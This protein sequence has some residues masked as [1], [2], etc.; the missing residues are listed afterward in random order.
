MHTGLRKSD[1]SL[2][3]TERFACLAGGTILSVVGMRRGGAL[4]MSLALGGGALAMLGLM[5]PTST[6]SHDLWSRGAP[7]MLGRMPHGGPVEVRCSITIGK[8]RH[9]VFAFFRRF[10]NLPRFMKHVESVTERADGSSHWVV[11]GPAGTHVE[12]D[13]LIESEVEG[14]RIAWR[15]REGAEVPNRG[16]VR[17]QDAPG[18][19]G[20]ELHLHLTYEPPAGRLGRAVAWL[21]G[22]EPDL[23]ARDDLRR[24]KQLLETGEVPTSLPHGKTVS[25]YH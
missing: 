13:S 2:S 21:L 3:D 23:Q 7:G 5:R 8:P 15:S 12:W 19:R 11:R 24:L 6:M 14:E 4:G 17:F 18:D 1:E 16:E 10:E 22:E 25:G 9:E 20:T